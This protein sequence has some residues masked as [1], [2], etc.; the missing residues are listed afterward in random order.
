[1]ADGEPTPPRK[2][3]GRGDGSE[4]MRAVLMISTLPWPK[5]GDPA[6][7]IICVMDPRHFDLGNPDA[8][9]TTNSH[10]L[11][12][13]V[14]GVPNDIVWLKPRHGGE[15]NGLATILLRV[16]PNGRR[17]WWVD[18]SV[19]LAAPPQPRRNLLLIG[20][21]RDEDTDIANMPTYGFNLFLTALVDNARSDGV[22]I[23]TELELAAENNPADG[24]SNDLPVE[25]SD[26]VFP[27]PRRPHR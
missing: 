15:V 11:F 24:V 26:R 8:L 9:G 4:Q 27:P 2:I 13:E 10:F 14:A 23:T 20:L 12:I 25:T 1:M 19:L 6:G 5:T 22:G 3:K 7:T 21:D 18:T 16:M 17:R